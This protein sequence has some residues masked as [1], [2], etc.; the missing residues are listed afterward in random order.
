MS[1]N[2]RNKLVSFITNNV[3]AGV[4]HDLHSKCSL[5]YMVR[6]VCFL[7]LTE[8]LFPKAV[9]NLVMGK[10]NNLSHSLQ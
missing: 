1:H 4:G 5:M 2:L 8:T 6:N 7:F 3:I 10:F 9:G